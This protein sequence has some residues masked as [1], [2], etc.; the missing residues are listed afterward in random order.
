[1]G[2]CYG[3]NRE[4]W[5]KGEWSKLMEMLLWFVGLAE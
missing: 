3:G 2:K 5:A 4:L 1:M